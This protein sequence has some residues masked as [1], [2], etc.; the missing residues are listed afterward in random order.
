[1]KQS[2]PPDTPLLGHL[3]LWLVEPPEPASVLPPLRAGGRPRL[4]RR[5][6]PGGKRRG[7]PILRFG[8]PWKL[9]DPTALTEGEPLQRDYYHVETEDGSA[10]LVYRD[11][12]TN[13]WFIQGALD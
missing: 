9:V 12:A 3:P 4:A 2:A 13:D 10:Y 8:G 6:A 5:G 7:T 11:R 1:V